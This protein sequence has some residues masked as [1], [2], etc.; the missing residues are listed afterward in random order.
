M[1]ARSGVVFPASMADI[2]ANPM[3]IYFGSFT[4]TSTVLVAT[5][6]PATAVKIPATPVAVPVFDLV[7]K[8]HPPRP[9]DIIQ[10]MGHVIDVMEETL[11]ICERA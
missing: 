8:T 11:Q 4:A 7:S 2:L 6:S 9:Y 1:V 5:T 3:E 10:G